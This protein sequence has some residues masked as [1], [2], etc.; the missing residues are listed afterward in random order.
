MK[1]IIN[2]AILKIINEL[3]FRIAENHNPLFA[4]AYPKSELV[5]YLFLLIYC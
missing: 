5:I 2:K 4:C 3:D 1:K